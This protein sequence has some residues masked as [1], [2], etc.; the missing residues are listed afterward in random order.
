MI[1]LYSSSDVID[2]FGR[3]SMDS[4]MVICPLLYDTG[5]SV[6][7]IIISMAYYAVPRALEMHGPSPAHPYL[8]APFIDTAETSLDKT[9][10][11]MGAK[12]SRLLGAPPSWMVRLRCDEMTGAE[13]AHDWAG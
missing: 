1:I 3:C 13:S 9:L 12:W 8:P 11:L 10:M 6:L 5:G 4:R 2:S 7:I